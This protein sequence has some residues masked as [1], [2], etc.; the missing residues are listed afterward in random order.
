MASRAI[1]T[2]PATTLPACL[3]AS[4]LALAQCT[5]VYPGAAGLA[6]LHYGGRS[7]VRVRLRRPHQSAPNVCPC[8]TPLFGRTE[9][10]RCF[11]HVSGATYVPRGVGG[12]TSGQGRRGLYSPGS[13]LLHM[14]L[15]GFG[16]CGGALSL[17]EACISPRCRWSPCI[18]QLMKRLQPAA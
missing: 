8:F 17:G 13:P 6:R 14:R 12:G 18:C 10:L 9:H 15:H 2:L 5:K 3:I 7:M 4:M 11:P 1:P 16:V